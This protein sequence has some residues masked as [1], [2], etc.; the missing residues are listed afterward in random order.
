MLRPTLAVTILLFGTT[1]MA[2]SPADARTDGAPTH[3][4]VAPIA[5]TSATRI[6][7]LTCMCVDASGNVYAGDARSKLVRKISADDRLLATF[8]PGIEPEAL[9]I[10][11]D[12]TLYVGGSRRV[13]ALSSSGKRL[14]WV[15]RVGATEVTSIAVSPTNVFVTRTSDM[16]YA[17]FRL[18][19]KLGAPAKIIEPLSGCCG[20][21]DIAWIRDR[22]RVAENGRKRVVTFDQ[23][24][25]QIASWAK[26]SEGNDE[27][28]DVFSGC[29]NPK[30]LCAAP[31][32]I[33]TS[34]SEIGLVKLYSLG[35]QLKAVIGR[36]KTPS[37][38]VRVTVGASPDG[39]RVYV[40]NGD[41][42]NIRVL[43]VASRRRASR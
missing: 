13:V 42:N 28:I 11:A 6:G 25:R 26:E 7:K 33:Y 39:S 23:A 20:Q 17:V 31:D 5:N 24:G 3:I 38:C 8:R 2:P 34:E 10:G 9:A 43:Q 30:N 32:G 1:A 19:R 41:T 36:V 18:T 15:W 40:L 12:G 37:G 29:C 35:G 27:G 4:E 22:L 16:G 21:M 14:P